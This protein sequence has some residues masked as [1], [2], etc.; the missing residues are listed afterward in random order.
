MEF[1]DECLRQAVEEGG[2]KMEQMIN[3]VRLVLV[4]CYLN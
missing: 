3:A 4:G 2:N 1:N